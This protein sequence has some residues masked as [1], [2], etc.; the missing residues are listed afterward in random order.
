MNIETTRRSDTT[1]TGEPGR[2]PR[3]V[4]AFYS[5]RRVAEQL[6]MSVRWV[7]ERIKA[8]ELD[9]YRLGCK[10]VVAAES[11]ANYLHKRRL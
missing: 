6:D 3:P 5:V 2:R 10:T 7:K 8:G 9:G 1:T 11:L 4:G